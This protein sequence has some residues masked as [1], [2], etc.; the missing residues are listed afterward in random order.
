[1]CPDCPSPSDLSNP[2]VLEAATESLA[3]FNRESPSKQY[4]VVK[5]TRAS[6]QVRLNAHGHYSNRESPMWSVGPTLR[7][8][9]QPCPLVSSLSGSDARSAVF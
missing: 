1:M 4:S 5:V 6:S 2:K 9:W 3:K 8:G 7:G